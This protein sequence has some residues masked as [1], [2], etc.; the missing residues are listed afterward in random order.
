MPYKLTHALHVMPPQLL[1]QSVV[2]QLGGGGEKMQALPSV[3]LGIGPHKFMA[4]GFFEQQ[5]QLTSTTRLAMIT[6]LVL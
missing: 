4:K 2:E 6:V 3:F 5:L 1:Q